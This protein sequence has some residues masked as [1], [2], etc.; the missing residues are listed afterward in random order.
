MD[1]IT[2]EII[3]LPTI[4]PTEIMIIATRAHFLNPVSTFSWIS[5]RLM[6][7]MAAITPIAIKANKNVTIVFSFRIA[8]PT[9]MIAATIRKITIATGKL[10]FLNSF[11]I[12][13]HS[14]T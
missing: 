10:T 4:I 8:R 14:F 9:A 3:Q 12:T 1:G 13:S 6:P 7:S 2:P 5:S 11:F